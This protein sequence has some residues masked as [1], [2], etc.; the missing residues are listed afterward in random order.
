M[1]DIKN[2]AFWMFGDV[3][4]DQGFWYSHQINTISGLKEPQFFWVPTSKSLCILWHIGHIAHREK[5]H[6]DKILKDIKGIIIPQKYEIF[7]DCWCSVKKLRSSID[8]VKNVLAWSHEVR[9]NSQNYIS[10]LNKKD[11]YKI[12]QSSGLSTELNLTVGHWLFIT[13]AH[14]SLHIGRIQLL[15]SIIENKNERAC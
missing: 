4:K 3:K 11:F 2:I 1:S 9:E 12:P 15:R 7:G 10:S 8:S 14:T 6:I 5:Y 13:A